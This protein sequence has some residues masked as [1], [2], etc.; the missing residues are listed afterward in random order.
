MLIS[1]FDLKNGPFLSYHFINFVLNTNQLLVG[2]TECKI[3][4]AI[5]GNN[6]STLLLIT[7]SACVGKQEPR[8]NVNKGELIPVSLLIQ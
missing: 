4:C 3:C 6:L 2:C 7:D 1:T 8:G 5:H